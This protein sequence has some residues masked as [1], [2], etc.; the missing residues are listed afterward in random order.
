MKRSSISSMPDEQAGRPIVLVT[1]LASDRS[2]DLLPL[3]AA[4]PPGQADVRIQVLPSDA[5]GALLKAI[6]AM[7]RLLPEAVI[8]LGP[9]ESPAESDETL[10][11][12][13]VALNIEHRESARGKGRSEAI[14]AAGPAAYFST[15]PVDAMVERMR[16]GG[17]PT[18]VSNSAG[19]LLCNRLFYATLHY[20][21]L[22]GQETWFKRRPPAGLVSR[23]GF[24]RLPTP[25]KTRTAAA[26]PASVEMKTSLRGVCLAIEAVADFLAAEPAEGL[27]GRPTP[28]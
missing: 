24:I 19:L 2:G 12:E 25:R 9:A 16:A 26:G 22:R 15:L 1:G 17:V 13:R 21:A 4:H 14:D 28:G 23:V 10:T 3:L 27:P 20:V 18:V 6:E 7:D 11:V 8:G 5:E